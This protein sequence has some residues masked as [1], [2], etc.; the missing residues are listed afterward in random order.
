MTN[1]EMEKIYESL[2]RKIDHFGK[3]KSDI[4]LVKLVLLLSKK[5]FK[6]LDQIL[7]YIEEAS[8]DLDN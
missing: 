3:Q 8:L 6:D 1:H 2:A 7:N 4:F 5:K